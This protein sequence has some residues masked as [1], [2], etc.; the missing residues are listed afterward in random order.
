MRP[1]SDDAEYARFT[2]PMR[3]QKALNLLEGY[4]VG[5]TADS[6]VVL[7]EV[8]TLVEWTEH[9]K[10]FVH[11][12][13]FNEILPAVYEI[14][15]A[16]NASDPKGQRDISEGLLWLVQNCMST[17]N[18]HFLQANHDMQ[19]LHGIMAGVIADRIIS[20]EE[21]RIVKEWC[22]AHE[23]MRSIYPYEEII[24]AIHHVLEDGKIDAT[25]HSEL[26]RFF[27]DIANLTT[28]KSI[29]VNLPQ[30]NS[31]ISALC[32]TAPMVH[33][34]AHTF[35]FTGTCKKA[36]RARYEE[37]VSD[38][39]GKAIRGINKHLHYLVVGAKS[40][41]HWAFARYGNKVVKVLENRKAGA[42]TQLIAEFDFWDAVADA[43]GDV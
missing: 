32:T 33:F 13:P 11:K 12:H 23:S 3:I 4:L 15:E 10:A 28:D 22:Y 9:Y 43:G 24:T 8:S 17:D 6:R 36:S 35:C 29:D 37:V 21:L 18:Y 42:T 27:G 38:L 25:E 26:M 1:A 20:E 30:F 41:P 31:E 34:S 19:K 7:Q 2:G 5:I 39:G 40:N 14:I 16:H